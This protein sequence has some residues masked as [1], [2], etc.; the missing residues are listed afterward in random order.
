MKF[1]VLTLLALGASSSAY[2]VPNTADRAVAAREAVSSSDI[3]SSIT[4]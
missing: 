3:D 2:V 1:T 4:N